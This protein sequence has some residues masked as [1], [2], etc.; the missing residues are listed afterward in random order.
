MK[1]IVS[2]F[3]AVVLLVSSFS[4]CVSALS[5]TDANSA[6]EAQNAAFKQLVVERLDV[7][8]SGKIEA[9]DAR[10]VLLASAGLSE[11][12]LKSE[13]N[14][15]IDGD[16]KVTAIDARVFLRLAAGLETPEKYV[17]FSDAE[18]FDYFKAIINSIKPNKYNFYIYNLE[19]NPS[20]SHNNPEMVKDI[21]EQMNDVASKFGMD[22]EMDFGKELTTPV[23]P[24][25]QTFSAKIASK[26]SIPVKGNDLACI[27]TLSNVKKVEYKTGETYKI[28][29]KVRQS[30]KNIVYTDTMA[31]LDSITVY[32]RDDASVAIKDSGNNF[33]SL[34]VATMLEALDDVDIALMK[35]QNA[36]SIAS[37]ENSF[38]GMGDF[39]FEMTP[40]T[41]RYHD[42]YVKVYFEPD[43]GKPI[44]VDYNL[45]YNIVMNMDIFI[46][47]NA[48]D[49]ITGGSSGSS[50]G[51]IL[52]VDDD[53]DLDTEMNVFNSY[54]F[55]DNNPNHAVLS[56]E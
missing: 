2:V 46:D 31:G 37:L 23:A 26:T 4:V 10:L 49:L 7:N 54:Y 55:F 53:V 13:A 51:Q 15:D 48:M 8:A 12:A 42:S 41:I 27:A 22:E 9:A 16:G 34:N 19:T 52:Y 40:K 30:S 44:A 50:F 45:R 11:D 20:V 47:I 14:A 6:L 39:D 33:D 21:N 24:V 36:D 32:I 43:T 35:R 5:V 56:A 18:K 17:A 38:S 29:T 25:S 28:E 1:K 3:C